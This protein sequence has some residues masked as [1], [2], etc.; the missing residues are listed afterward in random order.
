MELSS[1]L[2]EITPEISMIINLQ[3]IKYGLLADYSD[4]EICKTL[5]LSLSFTDSLIESHLR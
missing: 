2:K 3:N 4:E 5:L 1:K